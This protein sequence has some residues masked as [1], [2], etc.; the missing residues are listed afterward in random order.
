MPGRAN[1]EEIPKMAPHAKEQCR[2]FAQLIAAQLADGRPYLLGS[3]FSLADAACYH[4]VWF[5]RNFPPAAMVFDEFP[6]VVEWAERIRAMGQ[7]QRTD[8]S[9][10]EALAIAKQN[11]PAATPAADAR[12]PN[13]VK[14]GDRVTVTPDDYGFDPVAG[15]LV[16][17]SVHEVAVRRRDDQVGDLV[18]H[19]PRIG[20][21]VQLQ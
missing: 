11:T 12:E 10:D 20:F 21:R 13:G 7:G 19:F 15:E 17:S 9:P 2:G 6:Q 18:V 5:L 1:F 14:P 3:Q 16:A 8:M 4:P